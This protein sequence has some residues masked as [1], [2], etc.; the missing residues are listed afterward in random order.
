MKKTITTIFVAVLL[1]CSVSL[2]KAQSDFEGEIVYKIEYGQ[3]PDQPGIESFL[4]KEMK[5]SIKGGKT[6]MDQAFG[7]SGNSQFVVIDDE[8]QTGFVA[9]Y[10]MGQKMIINISEEDMKSSTE[11]YKEANVEYLDE[12]KDILDYKC[13]KAVLTQE[14]VTTTLYVTEKLPNKASRQF[15]NL[16][17]MPLQIAT[18]QEEIEIIMTAISVDKKAID[19]SIF[20]KPEGYQELSLQDIKNMGMGDIKF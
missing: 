4:P 17:G 15:M 14:G 2:S 18:S 12:Y 8:N 3:L 5:N 10:M 6:R 16:K 20:E 13:Q 11:S 19:S 1:I 9:S 7:E